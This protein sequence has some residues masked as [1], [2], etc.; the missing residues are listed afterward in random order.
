MGDREKRKRNLLRLRVQRYRQVRRRIDSENELHLRTLDLTRTDPSS[1]SENEEGEKSVEEVKP[2]NDDQGRAS[3]EIE[4]MNV[5]EDLEQHLTAEEISNDEESASGSNDDDSDDNSHLLDEESSEEEEPREVNNDD[6]EWN[7]V[8]EL[9]NW[10]I[11]SNI[12]QTQLDD[13]LLILRRRLLPGLPACSKTFL[14]TAAAD[15]TIQNCE[16]VDGSVGEFL[17]FGIA[18]NLQKTVNPT[19][20]EQT[21][22]RLQINIDGLPLYRSSSRQFWPIL[23]KVQFQPDV[24]KPFPIAI[25]SGTHKP[26]NLNEYFGS[27]I[28]EINGLMES[29]IVIDGRQFEVCIGC[30]ICDRPARSFIKCIKNHGGYYA[31]ER[32]IVKGERYEDRMVYTSTSCVERTDESFRNEENAQHHTGFSPLTLIRPGINM[33]CQFVLDFMHLCCLG[34]MKKLLVDCW[35]KGNL[36]T[37][38]SYNNKL[39]LSQRLISLQSQI[40]AEFQRTT[41]SIFDVLKWKATEFRFFLLYGGPVVLKKILSDDLYKHFLL[42][43]LLAEYCVQNNW[44]SNII[45]RPKHIFELLY[46]QHGTSMESRVRS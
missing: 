40:P 1:N 12:S 21:V 33:V 27:F 14:K 19:L 20:H 15:Y 39:L 31:C 2:L 22:L 3:N 36:N 44:L 30:F 37:R 4:G 29:G 34:I 41:R 28:E 6:Q 32:C 45:N 7:E 11:R 42:F 9:K 25:Y 23:G 46:Q 17:Y 16:H 5:A 35:L 26:N 38:L 8:T 43:P 13:L 18:K 24:Y 10:A